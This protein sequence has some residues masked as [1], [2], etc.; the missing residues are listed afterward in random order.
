MLLA[1]RQRLDTINRF[2]QILV[3][4]AADLVQQRLALKSMVFHDHD[5]Q[6]MLCFFHRAI[7]QC[8]GQSPSSTSAQ[9]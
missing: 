6:L 4:Q 1:K 2:Q 5:D 3:T 9:C 7:I 8:R